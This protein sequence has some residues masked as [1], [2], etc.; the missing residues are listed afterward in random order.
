[1]PL[2]RKSRGF[3]RPPNRRPGPCA[4]DLR[5]GD[6]RS[7]LTS[8]RLS[9]SESSAALLPLQRRRKT[10]MAIQSESPLCPWVM[11]SEA[12]RSGTI[13]RFA[14]KNKSESTG[15]GDFARGS[16]PRLCSLDSSE[17]PRCREL[18]PRNRSTA[19]ASVRRIRWNHQS[20]SHVEF[21]RD[22]LSARNGV[23][24]RGHERTRRGAQI[25]GTRTF[26]SVWT[27]ER[28]DR[29]PQRPSIRSRRLHLP[30]SGSSVVRE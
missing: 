8:R 20:A 9:R 6:D 27:T 4:P 25:F 15:L 28:A 24:R 10:T 18:R 13:L 7:S 2:P 29:T 21:S 19:F 5:A 26:V 17:S 16:V 3:R 11:R 12:L 14:P 30:R 23:I 22:S 1:V